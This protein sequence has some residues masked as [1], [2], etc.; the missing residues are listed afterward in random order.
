MDVKIQTKLLMLLQDLIDSIETLDEETAQTMSEVSW[1]AGWP[2]ASAYEVDRG[3]RA[4]LSTR[5][6]QFCFP[7]DGHP[8]TKH[9]VQL[10]RALRVTS[11]GACEAASVRINK[12]LDVT[13]PGDKNDNNE[14]SDESESST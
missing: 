1:D 3:L 11:N 7:H 2:N 9:W 8:F 5:M 4:L 6:S 13:F 12:R 14:Y 10:R